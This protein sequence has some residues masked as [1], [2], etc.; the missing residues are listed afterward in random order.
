MSVLRVWLDGQGGSPKG[1]KIDPYGG[2]EPNNAG[3]FD[4][5]VLNRLDDFMI[6]AKEYGIK[7]MISIH[8]FNSLSAGNDA[9]GKKWGTGTF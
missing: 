4:D 1:T 6:D 7:L 2:L 5:T 3:T 9:Y 8:S